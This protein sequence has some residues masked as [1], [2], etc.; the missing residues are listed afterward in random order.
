LVWFTPKN[1]EMRNT[2]YEPH[3]KLV[4]GNVIIYLS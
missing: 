4:L 1:V 2:A 3:Q